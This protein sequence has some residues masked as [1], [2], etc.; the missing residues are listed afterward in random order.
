MTFM[1]TRKGEAKAENSITVVTLH[2]A[3]GSRISV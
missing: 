1:E 3:A 2:S